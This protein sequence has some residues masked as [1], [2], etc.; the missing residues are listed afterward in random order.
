MEKTRVLGSSRE[1]IGFLV[2]PTGVEYRLQQESTIGRDGYSDIVVNDDAVSSQHA[3]IRLERGRFVVYDLA[4][5]NQTWV[6]NVPVQRQTLHD[7]DVLRVGNS[8]LVFKEV[9]GT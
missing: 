5:R 4:S 7:G 1:A 6:N 3:R 8:K 9:R 2:T